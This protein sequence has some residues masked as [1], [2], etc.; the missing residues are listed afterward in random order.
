MRDAFP[1]EWASGEVGTNGASLRYFRSGGTGRTLVFAH[2]F[3]DNAA[4]RL[5]LLS[6]LAS[7]YDVLAY[8]A[9]G[10]GLSDAPP[11]GY[12][13]EDRV[14]DLTGL[15]DELSIKSP[16]L[17]GH[18]TG[19]NTIL[20]AAACQPERPHALVAIDPAGL[21]DIESDPAVRLSNTRDRIDEW[22]DYSV[23]ELLTVDESI[24]THVEEGNERLARLLAR[25]R[26]QVHPNAALVTRHGFASPEEIYPEI[27]APALVLR[28]DGEEA[29][30]VR[31]R[32]RCDL[33]QNGRLVHID[34][35]SHTVV[36]DARE[37]AT[38]AIVEFLKTHSSTSSR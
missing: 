15:L 32:T 26:L 10:H 12:S 30:R 4:C 19:G 1:N 35:A 33:L 7:T 20:A 6:A 2:G 38:S 14:A 9:R 17:L 24:R 23:D 13:V 25:A 22:H 16:I 31:D 34:G 21:L 28:A 36:R 29:Q 5:P 11:T 8:D 37:E 18:S 3:Y 27:S